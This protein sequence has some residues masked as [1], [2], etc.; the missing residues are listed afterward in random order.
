MTLHGLCCGLH[1]YVVTK[2]ADQTKSHVFRK[3]CSEYRIRRT[4]DNCMPSHGEGNTSPLIFGL[5]DVLTARH[6]APGTLNATHRCVV[7]PSNLAADGAC[8]RSRLGCGFFL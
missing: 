6:D 4:P 3:L 2:V 7:I 5:I 1:R 8:S